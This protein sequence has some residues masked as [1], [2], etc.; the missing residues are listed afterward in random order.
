[1]HAD[2][3]PP[4]R[5]ADAY[6]H[7]TDIV[8]LHSDID[9]NAH[10]NHTALVRYFEHARLAELAPRLHDFKA[11]RFVLAKIEVLFLAPAHIECSLRVG[12][13]L[14][15]RGRTSFTIDQGL[16]HGSICSATMRAV[17]V[18]IDAHSGKPTE[19]TPAD[20]ALYDA[21]VPADR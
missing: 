17:A 14:H 16:F 19:L 7:W 13:R 11:S 21:L 12:S 3:T 15:A 6:P 9:F 5:R 10:I 4:P 18:K 2:A 8:P 1:M 20:A